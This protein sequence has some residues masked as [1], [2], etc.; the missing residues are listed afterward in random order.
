MDRPE[1]DRTA[2]DLVAARPGGAVV[3]VVV[4][5]AGREIA[6]PFDYLLP[7]ELA[8]TVGPGWRVK[9]PF[10]PSRRLEGW[11][12]RCKEKAEVPKERLRSVG[13]V[14]AA[15][16]PL[17]AP[18]LM[19]AGWLVDRYLCGWREA[20]SL[21]LP[22]GYVGG[23]Q[24]GGRSRLIRRYRLAEAAA[25]D[26][27]GVAAAATGGNQ[28]PARGKALAFL[29]DRPE[30]AT[31]KELATAGI[32]DGVLRGLR[33]QGAVVAV[34]RL[35]R[36]VPAEDGWVEK[37]A[38]VRLTPEQE[39]ALVAI[40]AEGA[41]AKPRPVLLQGVTGSGKTEV[42]LRAV[43]EA[44][45]RGRG[46]I[47][48]VPEISLTPQMAARFRTRFG[49]RVAVLHS[50]LGAG[51][52]YDEWQRLAR[53]EARVAL[54]ARS[55]VFA[56][57][58]GLG[59]LV[60]DEEHE[61]T[62]KQ[63]ESPRYHAR[64]VALAR[65]AA[66]GAVAVLGSATPAVE[67][68]FR[69][70]ATGEFRLV[71]LGG[72]PLG[73]P[74][75]EVRVVD[76]RAELAAGNREIFSRR[77]Q[78]A[79]RDRLA[80][81]EQALLFLNRRGFSRVVLC[82]A[83]G[84]VARCPFCHVALTY[85]AAAN[86]LLCHY[87]Q[88]RAAPPAAC[89]SCGSGYIRHFGVGTEKV[90]EEVRR[91]FPKARPVRMDVD[92]TRRKGAHGRILG[93]FARGEWNVLVGTQMIGKGLD[94]P[95]V[96]LVGVI[97]ADTALGLP[98]F[99]AAERTFTMLTQVAGRSGRG[100]R[101]GEVVVQTYNPDHYSVTAAARHDYPL[102]YEREIAFRRLAGYPPF[103][104]LILLT[105]AGAGEEQAREGAGRLAREVRQAVGEGAAVLGPSPAPLPRLRGRYR[106]QVL[107]KGELEPGSR[108]AVRAAAEE[109]QRRDEKL[110]VN[111]DVNPQSM[112]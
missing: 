26:E 50:R 42:Y 8:G 81:G 108:T 51:E 78:E 22:P 82:R 104:E 79:V 52:R 94:L 45:S 12:I 35:V 110:R 93:G 25:A 71:S 54:G 98:D 97:A 101:T 99:R 33:R 102:F 1:A 105:V 5:A 28:T 58:Q 9:V 10:G 91:F 100:S 111:W 72:R 84:L 66:E 106:F 55:A 14:V 77:L 20:L 39:A 46:A 57:L 27:D 34:D 30:G 65:A 21:F 38:P 73:R 47:V 70:V 24:E 80:A 36:R 29:A 85:H 32:G 112:L 41:A 13:G 96:T 95:G 7:P 76:M 56:P 83:C 64:E 109:I 37:A 49:E 17:P 69:A 43:A 61:G 60:V 18:A 89:P 92:T 2:E 87:C 62:Y 74:L 88:H 48:L 103:G 68:Y 40:R 63:E 23:A 90:E 6:R 107:V 16:P 19:V 11:V 15:C 67:S 75:P 3:E 31:R 4:D 44:L 53:G 86:C 59:L